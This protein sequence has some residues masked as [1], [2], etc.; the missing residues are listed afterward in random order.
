MKDLSASLIANSALCAR[1][2]IQKIQGNSFST[3]PFKP[4]A[5]ILVLAPSVPIPTSDLQCSG[6]M[7]WRPILFSAL[8]KHS[9]SLTAVTAWGLPKAKNIIL[10]WTFS[11]LP[12]ISQN[13]AKK[14]SSSMFPQSVLQSISMEKNWHD[15]IFLL[16]SLLLTRQYNGNRFHQHSY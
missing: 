1:H 4:A 6:L 11:S 9:K 8:Y 7:D 12:S 5:A 2:H 10:V 13:R 3:N 15:A 16:Q 14:I